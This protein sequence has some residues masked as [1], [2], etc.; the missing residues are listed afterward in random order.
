[1]MGKRDIRR[2]RQ[3]EIEESDVGCEGKFYFIEMFSVLPDGVHSIILGM[4]PKCQ[5]WQVAGG[6]ACG[7]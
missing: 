5:C 4:V 7:T 2:V 3:R 1:M 6:G